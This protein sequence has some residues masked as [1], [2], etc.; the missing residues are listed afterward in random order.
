VPYSTTT[1]ATL[2]S[3]LQD[4]Y[5]DVVFW[6]DQDALDAINE[7]LRAFNAY[8]GYWR[9]SVDVLTTAGSPFVT[10]SAS[11]TYRTRVFRTGRAL[12][13]KSI[14]EQFRG[15]RNWRT[16]TTTTGGTIPTTIREWSPIG[17]QTIATWPTDTVGG[18]TLTIDAVKI[19]PVLVADGDFIDLGEEEQG[20]LLDEALYV[21]GFK[22]PSLL[23]ALQPRHLSFLQACA[24]KSDRLR[25]S[26]FYKNILGLDQQQRTYVTTRPLEDADGR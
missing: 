7:A 11:L 1:L 23:A 16:E 15:R 9:G 14:V 3:R 12:T 6:T 17:L 26:A 8:T 10:V 5:D 20:A 2:R 4:R 25:A 13:R 19:T 21:L 18:T 22:Q 24:T